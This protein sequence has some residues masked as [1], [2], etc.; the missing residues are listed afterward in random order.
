MAPTK[1]SLPSG[2]QFTDL[3]LEREPRSKR[4]LYQPAPMARLLDANNVELSGFLDDEDL[5]CWLIAEFYLMH[6]TA[7]GEPDPVA[8]QMLREFAALRPGEGA[9]LPAAANQ[10]H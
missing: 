7:G 6:R 4:L 3:A 2:L 9:N 8:E 5:V 10:S 1:I